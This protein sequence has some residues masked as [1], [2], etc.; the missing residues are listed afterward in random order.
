MKGTR[1][2]EQPGVKALRG[3]QVEVFHARRVAKGQTV[4]NN[5]ILSFIHKIVCLSDPSCL[6]F[7]RVND[8]AANLHLTGEHPPPPV[9]CTA[10]FV[11]LPQRALRRNAVASLLAAI[12]KGQL[13][14]GDW[15]NAQKLA[16][17]FGV[18]ATPVRE[19]LVELAGVGIVEMQHNRGTTVRPFG[20]VQ[21]QDIYRLRR[22]LETEATRSACGHIPVETLTALKREMVELLANRKA[23]H[24]SAR[25]MKSDRDLH[26]LVAQH[27]GSQRLA[28]EIKRYD[29]L[30][31]CIR[32]VVGNQSAAQQRALA[33]HLEIIEPLLT[34]EIEGAA[35]AMASHIRKTADR[36][37][38]ALFPDTGLKSNE[39]AK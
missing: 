20:P 18:S 4:V 15:L 11:P 5:K 34:G 32:D 7:P 8:P 29:T 2:L 17:Q 6:R 33:E 25:A 28:E 23:P 37:E 14:A 26:D 12:F 1:R 31:Q 9:A 38:A 36:I 21:L 39:S 35:D 10:L 16:E 30:I 22:V 24:W 3:Q 19:A 13:K 27:C